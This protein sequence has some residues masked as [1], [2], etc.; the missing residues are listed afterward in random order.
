[1]EASKSSEKELNLADE[2]LEDAEILYGM[3][4][5]RFAE[6]RLYYSIFHAARALLLEMGMKA[7]IT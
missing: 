4:S 6:S 7:K 5:L 2:F 1:M 3:G